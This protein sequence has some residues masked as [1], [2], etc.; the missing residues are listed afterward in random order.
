MRLGGGYPLKAV[1]KCLKILTDMHHEMEV[2]LG[3]SKGPICA[4]F[5]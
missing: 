3:L 1:S 2:R 4:S 5:N